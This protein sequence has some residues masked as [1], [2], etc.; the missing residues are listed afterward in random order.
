MAKEWIFR[1][2]A[3]RVPQ[4]PT[5]CLPPDSSMENVRFAIPRQMKPAHFISI[6]M[7]FRTWEY[8]SP[9]VA[10]RPRS[11]G[12][13]QLYWSRVPGTRTLFDRRYIEAAAT[14]GGLS[15]RRNGH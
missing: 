5:N 3:R 13:S 15:K 12:I 7:T 8:G 6:H 1:D 2:C 14:Y 10:C 11:A 4:L 9:S